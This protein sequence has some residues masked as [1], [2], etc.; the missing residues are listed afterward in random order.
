M[1]YNGT[2]HPQTVTF[3][4]YEYILA[5]KSEDARSIRSPSFPFARQGKQ[6]LIFGLFYRA[7]ST[8]RS[9]SATEVKRKIVTHRKS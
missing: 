5:N 6:S 2:N 3:N 9:S 4:I 7:I 8:I 1:Y